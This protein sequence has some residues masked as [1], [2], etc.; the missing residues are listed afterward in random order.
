MNMQCITKFELEKNYS[1]GHSCS[2]KLKDREGMLFV[3]TDG[4][5]VDPGEELFDHRGI[6]PMRMA[7]FEMNGTKLWEKVQRARQNR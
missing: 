2:V 4:A 5:G 7:M 3:Y 6:K 1:Y